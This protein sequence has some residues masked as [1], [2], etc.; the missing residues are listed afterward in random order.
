MATGTNAIATYGDLGTLA[1]S[2]G[3]SSK[4]CT[5]NGL[6]TFSIISTIS[7]NEEGNKCVR[8]DDL[9]MPYIRTI[10][11]TPVNQNT[12]RLIYFN[13][14]YYLEYTFYKSSVGATIGYYSD[15]VDIFGINSYAKQNFI[16]VQ[17]TSYS[18]TI[19]N[20]YFEGGITYSAGPYGTNKQASLNIIPGSPALKLKKVPGYSGHFYTGPVPYVTV[21]FSYY[22]KT[23]S[24]CTASFPLYLMLSY[25]YI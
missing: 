8:Y 3:S 20:E 4:C 1:A 17:G 7:M 18:T 6:N 22:N 9:S 21:K 14:R 2:Y 23:G 25:A 19:N 5:G 16:E 10:Y 15:V 11:T 13:E 12:A 24:R